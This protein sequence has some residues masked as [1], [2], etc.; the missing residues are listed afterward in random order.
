MTHQPIVAI[1]GPTATGK[2]T[3][4]IALAQMLGGEVVSA[5]SR[6]VYRGLNLGTGKVTADEAHGV[7]HH[8]IDV[9]DPSR[10]FT[11]HDFVQLGRASIDAIVTRGHTPLVV[12]GTGLY[13]DALLGRR[14]LDAP[15]PDPALRARLSTFEFHSL[16][17]ELRLVDPERYART[18][19]KNRRRVERALEVTLSETQPQKGSAVPQYSVIWV[20]LTLP[21][22]VLK[23][24]IVTRLHSRLAAGMLDEARTLLSQGVTLTRMEELGLEYRYMARHLSGALTYTEM[25]VSLESE[26]YKY[27]KRQMTWFKPNTDI[28]WLDARTAEPHLIAQKLRAHQDSNLD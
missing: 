16:I 15:P 1:V 21:R 18:D 8:L 10:R 17:D 7:P 5:D 6:Q 20:G 28:T 19:L 11:V 24:R 26:I 12:G 27:A 23:E 3:F 4:G 22:E 13:V 9:S 2:T 14:T 25:V